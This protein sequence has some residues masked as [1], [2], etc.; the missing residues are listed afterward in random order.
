MPNKQTGVLVAHKHIPNLDI[1]RFFAAYSILFMHSFSIE[2]TSPFYILVKNMAVGVD[3]FFLISGFLITMLLLGEKDNNRK[4]SLKNF[5]IRRALRIWPLYY[6]T[7]LFSYVLLK[8]I[9][10]WGTPNYLYHIFF[11]G[12]FE[13]IHNDEWTKG[14]LLH[15]W[16]ICIEEH[17]YLFIPIIIA[18]V[19]KKWLP[20]IFAACILGC[21]IFRLYHVLYVPKYWFTLYVHTLS[22]VDV[23]L[24]GC[25]LGWL[26]N[27]GITL[28]LNNPTRVILFVGLLFIMSIHS[29]QNYDGI[30]NGVFY[31]YVYIVPIAVLL[32]DF[33][34]TGGYNIPEHKGAFINYLGKC[35]YA[36][37]MLHM[38]ILIW[39]TYYGPDFIKKTPWLVVL[40]TTIITL[41]AA[42]L[43]YNFLE[44]PF[45]KL[46]DK[47]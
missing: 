34:C 32:Y 45:L 5:Y 46:K 1:L 15:L 19:K 41:G 13:I 43:S 38:L 18:T 23:L 40:F 3:V 14:N 7:L 42:I 9:V 30:F 47:L 26:Y 12:N 35:S 4:V 37:Y 2:Q 36:I 22:R 39:P 28:V 27:R 20:Y 10:N 16:S 31:K 21:I 24:I 6:A 17:F 11:A 33:V 29:V 44:K 8:Y 25:F